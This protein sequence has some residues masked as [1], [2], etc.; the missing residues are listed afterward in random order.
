MRQRLTGEL[1]L[2]FLL[3][4]TEFPRS[5]Q[6]C[7]TRV[8]RLLPGMPARPEVERRMNRTTGLVRNADPAALVQR[9]PAAF[10]DEIQ[11]RLGSLHDAIAEGYFHG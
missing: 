5:V 1:A 2:R 10:M 3:Q 9:D 11:V 6:F 8:Q 4:N 7:L